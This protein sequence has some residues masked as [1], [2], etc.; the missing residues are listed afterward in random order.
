ME[1]TDL[2][3]TRV[4]NDLYTYSGFEKAEVNLHFLM[5]LCIVVSFQRT[6]H[7]TAE[8]KNDFTVE[9]SDKRYLKQMIKV[10][11]NSDKSF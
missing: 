8:K 9:E 1:K 5:G 11:I 3:C 10:S 2:L 7:D 4:T 6:Q